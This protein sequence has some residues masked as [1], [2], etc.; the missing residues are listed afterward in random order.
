MHEQE[1]QIIMQS[2]ARRSSSVS[3]KS[4]WPGSPSRTAAWHVRQ[5][6]S[7]QEDRIPTPASSTTSRIE[8]PAA[9]VQGATALTVAAGATVQT[10]TL[11]PLGPMT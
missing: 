1:T 4:R 5:V 2:P 6:P 11:G 9:N 3:M 7:G 8:R 10:A